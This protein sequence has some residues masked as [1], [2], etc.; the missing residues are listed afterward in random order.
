MDHLAETLRPFT[1]LKNLHV[2]QR[3]R[4]RLLDPIPLLQSGNM[5][6]QISLV[7]V[8][9]RE[10]IDHG[11]RRIECFRVETEGAVAWVDDTGRVLRQEFKSPAGKVDAVRRAL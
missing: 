4:L 10:P 5:D 8:T 2:G 6:L 7:T 3:W 9:G 1:H 11:G